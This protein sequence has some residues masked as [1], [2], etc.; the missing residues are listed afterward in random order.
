MTSR[1]P[2]ARKKTLRPGNPRVESRNPN[3]LEILPSREGCGQ[4]RR[5]PAPSP[6]PAITSTEA[7]SVH[8]TDLAA[9]AVCF[10]WKTLAEHLNTSVRTLTRAN[11]MGL[12]PC[13]DLVCGR[14]PRWSP[15]SIERWLRTKPRLPG[16]KG[17]NRGQ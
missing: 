12:L 17:V 3:A 6:A 16:R 7:S 13:P 14:S 1:N 9:V 2:D 8:E 11:A 10:T 5:N 4:Q 15:S